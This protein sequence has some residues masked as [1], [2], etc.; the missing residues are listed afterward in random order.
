MHIYQYL[1]LIVGLLTVLTAP[2]L[3]W[4]LDNGPAT[5]RFLTPEERLIACQRVADNQGGKQSTEFNWPQAWEALW[6]PLSWGFVILSFCWNAGASVSNV[7]GPTI[8]S[9]LGFSGR[10]TLLLNMPFGFLQCLV[11]LT[12]CAVATKW[13][14]KSATL[15]GLSV[16]CILGSALL[17]AL[18]RSTKAQ[19]VGCLIS[20]YLLSA[21][22]AANPLLVS[23]L[24]ANT[25]GNTKRSIVIT[26]F[27]C[28]SSAGNIVGPLLFKSTDAP[29]YRQG[30]GAVMGLFAAQAG[31]VGILVFG[32]VLLNRRKMQKR[33]E[34]GKRASV[35]L[36]L[37]ARC[38][39]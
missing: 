26:L 20:Y 35:F 33:L 34:L 9:S 14:Y 25:G 4:R 39:C 7:F 13:R 32:L 27:Q 10:E 30:L 2:V 17:Y 12:A 22:F 31:V 24:V 38:L 3:Y 1:F 19:Q 29:L 16:P 5:A 11:I 6:S 28:G 15:A 37:S 21:L 23:W 18:P 8:I 36:R